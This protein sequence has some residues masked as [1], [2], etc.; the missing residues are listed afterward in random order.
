M[1][2]GAVSGTKLA[3]TI[4]SAK[5][6]VAEI[7]VE[8]AKEAVA[9]AEEPAR[10]EAITG[11]SGPRNGKKDDLTKVY[12]IDAEAEATLNGLGIYHFDQIAA[13]TPGQSRWLFSQFGHSG[14]FPSWWWRWKYDA[15]QLASGKMPDTAG[16]PTGPI[17]GLMDTAG[18]EQNQPG[19]A[20]SGSVD[21]AAPAATGKSAS[22]GK[23]AGQRP[24]PA[25]STLMPMKG[26]SQSGW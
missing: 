21:D 4:V 13:M 6:A 3:T 15:D 14:R 24:L 26:K 25:T 7:A 17:V 9:K 16:M 18:G 22:E 23:K 10:E 1:T 19:D 11:L 12:G 2:A 8:P 20:V 5:S